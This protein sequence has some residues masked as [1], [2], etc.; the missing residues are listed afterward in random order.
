MSPLQRLDE[1]AQIA[2]EQVVDILAT[3]ALELVEDVRVVGIHQHADSDHQDAINVTWRVELDEEHSYPV[4]MLLLS[5]HLADE[6]AVV[7]SMA[8][9]LLHNIRG[10]QDAEPAHA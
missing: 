7:L 9:W 1:L 8:A 6:E 3:D 2:A 5:E 4:D 10:D